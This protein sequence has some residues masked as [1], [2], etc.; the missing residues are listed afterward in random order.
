[1]IQFEKLDR[2]FTDLS[3]EEQDEIY[4]LKWTKIPFIPHGILPKSH[5]ATMQEQL[6]AGKRRFFSEKEPFSL[7]RIGDFELGLLGALFFPF[8]NASNTITTMFTR[9]GYT[10]DSLWIRQHMIASIRESALV[11]VLE[12]WDT[13][14]IETA[15]LLAMLDCP[16]PFPSAVEIHLPYQMLVDGSLLTWLSGRKVLLIGNLAPRLLEVWKLPAFH[17]AREC[18]GPSSKVNI[19]GAIPISSREEGG[20]CRDFHFALQCAERLDYDVALVSCGAMAKP[21]VHRISKLGRTALDVGFVFDALLGERED[22][23]QLRPVLR[24]AVFPEPAW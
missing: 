23:R 6:E 14:M 1:V 8:G 5:G 4:R 11:G 2:W 7:V 18:F 17:K 24:D 3:K 9:A 21:L 20:G 19:V 22:A 16:L 13:Q 12:N 15:S 10:P